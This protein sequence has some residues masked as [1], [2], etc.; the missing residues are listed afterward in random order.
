CFTILLHS[1]FFLFLFFFFFT[2]PP[3]SDIYTLSLHDALPIFLLSFFSIAVHVFSFAYIGNPYLRAKTPRPLIWSECSCVTKM[4]FKCLICLSIWPNSSS[5]F[6][7][8]RPASTRILPLS[9]ST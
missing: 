7:P 8:V 4:P 5:I 1:L 3:T 6:L 9:L 2:A